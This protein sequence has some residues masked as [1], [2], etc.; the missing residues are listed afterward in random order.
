M[1]ARLDATSVEH[2]RVY[3]DTYGRVTTRAWARF[4]EMNEAAVDDYTRKPFTATWAVVETETAVWDYGRIELTQQTYIRGEK[5]EAHRIDGLR[6]DLTDMC[7]I[8]WQDAP[9]AAYGDAMGAESIAAAFVAGV[10]A[11]A[12]RFERRVAK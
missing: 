7:P 4:D 9:L 6:S 1:S 10:E 8:D 12:D 11:E 5:G 2:G 3:G